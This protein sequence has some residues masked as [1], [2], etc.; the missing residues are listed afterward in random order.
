MSRRPFL[1]AEEP[2]EALS[3]QELKGVLCGHFCRGPKILLEPE[4][5]DE[6]RREEVVT[7]AP[8]TWARQHM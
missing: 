2:T 4:R 8:E 1:S 7:S 5:E 3:N 6:Q